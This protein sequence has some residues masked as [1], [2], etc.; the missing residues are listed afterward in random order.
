MYLQGYKIIGVGPCL[1]D[2]VQFRVTALLPGN[3]SELLPYLNAALKFCTYEDYSDSLTLKFR[4]YPVILQM[5]RII[6]GQLR[7]V[8]AAEEILDAVVGFI[9]RIDEQKES[10][11]PEYTVKELPQPIEI[12]NLLPKTNCNDCDETTCIA[13]AVKLV[14]G[15]KKAEECSHL[16]P[17]QAESIYAIL[18]TLDD[19]DTLKPLK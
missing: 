13:F 1:A 14:K 3:I 10:I 6:V 4:G 16:S 8:D 2:G 12:Y 9:N 11:K 7:E 18:D 15:E 17:I 5:D 19:S